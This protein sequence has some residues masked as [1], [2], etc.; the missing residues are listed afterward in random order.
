MKVGSLYFNKHSLTI[1]FL[2]LMIGNSIIIPLG[3]KPTIFLIASIFI[4]IYFF[5]NLKQYV[6]RPHP[7]IILSSIYI[8]LSSI[9]FFSFELIFIILVISTIQKFHIKSFEYWAI[10]TL[11]FIITIIILEFFSF[12]QFKEFEVGFNETLRSARVSLVFRN[13][14]TIYVYLST[15]ICI[16]YNTNR[17]YLIY[18]I[19]VFLYCQYISLSISTII[20][21]LLVFVF[22]FLSI[23]LKYFFLKI[24][25]PVAVII[26]YLV[27]SFYELLNIKIFG[28]F[29]LN[30]LTS[31]RL[32][33]LRDVF[34]ESGGLSFFNIIFGFLIDDV[35]NTWVEFLSFGMFGVLLLYYFVKFNKINNYN[36]PIILFILF[37]GNVEN[38]VSISIPL[39]FYA[40][41]LLN[42][43]NHLKKPI[44]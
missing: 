25:I 15:C 41:Y 16:F 8:L 28:N 37:Y 27:Y 36:L 9:Y 12:V 2:L 24:L 3:Y 20:S 19:L 38:L 7:I 1:F 5:I 39:V 43:S 40:G 30:L 11:W 13:P 4:L 33:L 35:D 26:P 10:L 22:L 42:Y 6:R 21:F 32:Q 14:N 18:T 29:D 44:L 17:K 31:F 23:R 34:I